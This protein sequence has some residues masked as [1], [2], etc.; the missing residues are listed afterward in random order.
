MLVL[1][2]VSRH[3]RHGRRMPHPNCSYV[4]TPT[5]YC[6]TAEIAP[7]VTVRVGETLYKVLSLLNL[8]S[9]HHYSMNVGGT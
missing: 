5:A 7:Q 6:N 4:D 2:H 1:G 8:K 9:H 3:L